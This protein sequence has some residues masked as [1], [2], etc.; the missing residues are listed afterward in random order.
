MDPA[1]AASA[2]LSLGALG[3]IFKVG[4]DVFSGFQDVFGFVL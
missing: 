2:A 3:N 1:S 4:G